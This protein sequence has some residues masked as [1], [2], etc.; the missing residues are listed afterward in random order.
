MMVKRTRE[1][2]LRLFCCMAA[3]IMVTGCIK[4]DLSDC[5]VSYTLTVRA[6]DHS[7]VEL[8]ISEVEAVSL[9][10]FD[11]STRFVRKI[12]TR[13]GAQVAI[14]DM[15]LGEDIHIVAWGNLNYGGQTY[16][17][18]NA[19]ELLSD[20]FVELR[21][22]SRATA[23]ALSPGDLF[24]GQITIAANDRSGGKVLPIYREVGSLA[25][26]IVNLKTFAGF[27]DNDYSIVVRESYQNIGFNGHLFGDKVSYLPSG[28][29]MTNNG[30]EE[31]RV[32]AFSMI[33]EDGGL[34]I[35]IYHGSQLIATV[36]RDNSGEVI[37]VEKGKQSNVLI[38]L[39]STG[40]INVS[41]SIDNWGNSG[42]EK[43]F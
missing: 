31:Y 6:Y 28:S 22:T 12:D 20:C 19:G 36:S 34:Y 25:I 43:E 35:D 38:K 14:N 2:L 33:P 39:S 9:F 7:G 18:P 11:G 15:P 17:T 3:A 13:I 4:D 26:T 5:G 40:D 8:G 1:I 21:P 10:V 24:R 37:I 29:F 27:A 30:N 16:S 41:V 42:G 32:P 23:Y